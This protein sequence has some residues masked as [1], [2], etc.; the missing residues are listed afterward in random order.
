MSHFGLVLQN[1][2]DHYRFFF[3]FTKIYY[4]YI[5]YL[6]CIFKSSAYEEISW[7]CKLA[8]GKHDLSGVNLDP[9]GIPE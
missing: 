4:G 7:R 3:G 1:H 2:I 8:R 5:V 9:A 6:S